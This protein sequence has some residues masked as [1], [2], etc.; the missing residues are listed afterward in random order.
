MKRR[1]TSQSNR[2]FLSVTLWTGFALGVAL[3]VGMASY[4]LLNAP[5]RT[6]WHP[7]DCFELFGPLAVVGLLFYASPRRRAELPFYQLS[8]VLGICKKTI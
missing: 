6:R 5:V 4:A 1:Q 8:T 3:F 2:Q 7:F